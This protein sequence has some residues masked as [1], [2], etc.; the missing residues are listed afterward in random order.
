M[1]LKQKHRW[2]GCFRQKYFTAGFNASASEA[3][4]SSFKRQKG[5]HSVALH[6]LVMQTLIHEHRRAVNLSHM[7]NK[8]AMF[9]VNPG[10]SPAVAKCR[11]VMS[12]YATNLY[13]E[14]LIQSESYT[15]ESSSNVCMFIAVEYFV[16][17]LSTHV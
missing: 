17:A 2:V 3:M 10:D 14:Q 5:F 13:E 1:R 12:D 15:V 4:N 8:L 6:Q 7:Q 9:N 11:F 16:L